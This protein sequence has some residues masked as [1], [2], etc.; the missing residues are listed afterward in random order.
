MAYMYTLYE[1]I[2]L[3]LQYN[4]KVLYKPKYY[5]HQTQNFCKH[6]LQNQCD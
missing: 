4:T 6:I 2:K 1:R 5:L 3:W